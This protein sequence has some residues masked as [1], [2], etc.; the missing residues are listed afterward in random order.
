MSCALA[1]AK[2][3]C[4]GTRL[5]HE[6]RHISSMVVGVAKGERW[7]DGHCY[8][9]RRRHHYP[10]HHHHHLRMTM[11][12]S[13]MNHCHRHHYLLLSQH[14]RRQA[15]EEEEVICQSTLMGKTLAQNLPTQV[16]REWAL[17]PSLGRV[18]YALPPLVHPMAMAVQ[19]GKR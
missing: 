1:S 10:H 7:T 4:V 14:H 3:T 8:H 12:K 19:A 17:D 15:G 16:V 13:W 11:K 5:N 2:P 6:R 18:H 9:R